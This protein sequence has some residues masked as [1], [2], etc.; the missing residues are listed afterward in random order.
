METRSLNMVLLVARL[1][2]FAAAARQLEVDPSAVSR[3]V[4]T[5]EAELGFRLFQ[6]STRRLSLTET[7]ARYLATAEPLLEALEDARSE[8]KDLQANP[9]GHLRITAST[10]FGQTCLVPLLPDFRVTF[11]EIELEMILTEENLDLIDAQIDLALR[12]APAPKGDLISTRL[13]TTRFHICAS[14]GYLERHRAPRL[15]KDLAE[16]ECLRF[17]LPGHRTKWLLKDVAGRVTE[18]PVSGHV[19]LSNALALRDAARLGLGPVLLADWLVGEDIAE[20]R[21]VD[22]FPQHRATATEFDTGAW[23]LYPS[24]RQVPAKVRA[25]LD[26]LRARLR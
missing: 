21:L 18:V 15:P 16:H 17:A 9:S 3:V 19:M 22:L 13:M 10:A 2:S 11:P 4:A 1:G 26:F 5:V 23:A 8:A 20:G 6:R 25:T 12:L 14:P 24:R 7:G